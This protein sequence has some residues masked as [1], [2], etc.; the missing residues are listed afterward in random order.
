MSAPAWG[1]LDR[2]ITRTIAPDPFEGA[3]RASA[4]AGLP[5]YDVSPAQG[6]LLEVLARSVRAERVLE[7]G[8]LAGYSALWLARSGARVVT[9][10]VSEA[11]AR[12]ARANFA[13][14]G[15]ADRIE[16]VVGSAADTLP[17]IE[18][19]FDL[20]FVDADKP[21]NPLYLEHALRVARVGALIVVDNVVREGRVLDGSSDDPSVRGVRALFDRVEREPRLR[22]TA[23]QTV[24]AKGHDGFLIATV[25]G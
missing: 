3:L 2:W 11:H 18:G 19:P 14:A 9:L 24:G 13:R 8:T 20:V 6:A 25:L 7:V 23:I 16:L 10:E 5:A 4:E 22:A 1:D 12:V 15:L 17:S 21:S